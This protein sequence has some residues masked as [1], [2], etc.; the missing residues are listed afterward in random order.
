MASISMWVP[1]RPVLRLSYVPTITRDEMMRDHEPNSSQQ[2]SV[3][4]ECVVEKTLAP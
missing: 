2:L 4:L 1:E 3:G